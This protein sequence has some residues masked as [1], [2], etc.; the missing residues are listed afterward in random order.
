MVQFAHFTFDLHMMQLRSIVSFS[1]TA[2]HDLHRFT[3]SRPA[4][5]I[6]ASVMS[7]SSRFFIDSISSYV[8]SAK[9]VFRRRTGFGVGG[10]G[11]LFNPDFFISFG[12]SLLVDRCFALFPLSRLLVLCPLPLL[13]FVSC[14]VSPLGLASSV[15]CTTGLLP[16]PTNDYVGIGGAAVSGINVLL[17]LVALL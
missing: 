9:F 4:P 17:S 14:R 3:Q 10:L 2:E 13:G 5:L 1:T 12:G 6:P 15:G 11:P 16:S 7:S 8:A